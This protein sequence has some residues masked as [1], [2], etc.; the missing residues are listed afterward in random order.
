MVKRRLIL[1]F[2]LTIPLWGYSQDE[3]IFT[4]HGMNQSMF[5]P[6]YTVVNN[7]VTLSAMSR[8]QWVGL[9]GAPFTNTFIGSTTF[10]RNKGGVGLTV[11]NNSY[12]VS[13][14][15]EI[16]TQASYKII[17]G[18]SNQLS[19]GLQGG[20]MSFESNFGDIDE[21]I[22]DPNFNQNI[23]EQL[24]FP[25]FGFGVFFNTENFY[26][27]VS[28]PKYLEYQSIEANELYSYNRHV[29]ISSGYVI[30]VRLFQLKLSAVGIYWDDQF[31]YEANA[32][33]LF[34]NSIWA[35]VF[36]R[37]LNAFGL[38]G[39]FE[40]TDRLK[41][42]LTAELPS[43]DLVQNQYGSYEAFISFEIAPFSRQILPDRYF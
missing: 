36:T 2:L 1:L 41:F 35:G 4:Q 12:G 16:F 25:N 22:I 40:L 26:M 17:L 30:P 34:A 3:A 11:H 19:M 15:T 13:S 9:E 29:Y 5:N 37:D 32:A 21:A 14:N 7:I 31:S 24:V 28:I 39:M 6:A 20:Y 18:A 10:F 42:G 23:V 38:K 33:L 8:V 43:T 27:G